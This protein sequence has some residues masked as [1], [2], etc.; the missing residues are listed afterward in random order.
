MP[1][2]AGKYDDL[3]TYVREKA[4]AQGAIV[5][6]LNGNKGQG[7]AMQADLPSTLRLADMLEFMAKEIR[8]SLKQ[9]QL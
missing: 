3:C 5:V 2:G 4:E 8:A 9:G 1:V 6:I 7:F